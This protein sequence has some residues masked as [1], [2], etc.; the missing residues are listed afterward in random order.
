MRRIF[1]P[2]SSIA[3]IAAVLACS[4]MAL[5]NSNPEPMQT[6]L[7]ADNTINVIGTVVDENDEPLIGV[8]VV[9]DGTKVGAT[10][11]IDGRFSLPMSSKATLVVSYEG[12]DQI[13][14]KYDYYSI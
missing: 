11:Y 14:A 7:M 3:A 2:I 10:T 4:P 12:Y 6:S 5:A 8:S 9:V 1:R 13:N